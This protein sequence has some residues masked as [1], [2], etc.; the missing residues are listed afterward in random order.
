V[1]GHV[2]PED[3][4]GA[5]QQNDLHPRRVGGKA[6]LKEP[7]KEMAQRAQPPQ[8]GGGQPAH[9]RAVTV[10]ERGKTAMRAFA[11]ELFV[12]CN[13]AT[14]HAVEN[15]SRDP[16]GGEPGNFRLRRCARTHHAAILAD[17]LCSGREAGWKNGYRYTGLWR[18]RRSA[19][20]WLA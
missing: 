9:Q 10:S 16:A 1:I 2:E 14:Q 3:L 18:F 17:E 4:C 20:R 6:L 7:G 8:H 13:A 12:E 19:R 11:A 5:N 15:V